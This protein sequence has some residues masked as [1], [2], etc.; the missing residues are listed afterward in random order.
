MNR[1]IISAIGVILTF[2]WIV[3][4]APPR[5]GTVGKLEN[6]P[7][8]KINKS[9]S[10]TVKKIRQPV[11]RVIKTHDFRAADFLLFSISNP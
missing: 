6:T 4:T 1:L 7:I 3:Y 5:Q 2:I 9:G 8:K 11:N 10:T